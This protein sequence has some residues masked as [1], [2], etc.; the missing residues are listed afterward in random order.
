M[1]KKY[2]YFMI[3]LSLVLTPGMLRAG[4]TDLQQALQQYYSGDPAGA[5]ERLKSMAVQEPNDAALYYYLGYF[6]QEMGDYGAA[7][8][9]FRKAYEINPDFLPEVKK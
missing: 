1:R 5:V 8:E 4:E 7:R 3:A 2:L 6:E 9:A